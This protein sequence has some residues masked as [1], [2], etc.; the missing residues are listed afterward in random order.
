[1]R[2]DGQPGLSAERPVVVDVHPALYLVLEAATLKELR[3]KS[4]FSHLK[5]HVFGPWDTFHYYLITN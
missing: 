5:T 3:T 4:P 2:P 1:M